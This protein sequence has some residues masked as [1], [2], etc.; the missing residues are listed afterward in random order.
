LLKSIQLFKRKLSTIPQIL[1]VD[2]EE[3]DPLKVIVE[4]RC[5]ASGFDYKR[6]LE[7]KGIF[8]ELADESRVLLVLPLTPLNGVDEMIECLARSSSIF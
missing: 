3:V 1:V 6:A 8:V 7:E 5:E 2:S 4:S